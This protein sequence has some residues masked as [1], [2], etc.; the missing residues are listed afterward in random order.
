MDY[1][2]MDCKFGRFNIA[3]NLEEEEIDDLQQAVI[4]YI[5]FGDFKMLTDCIMD[6]NLSSLEKIFE[7]LLERTSMSIVIREAAAKGLVLRK[8]TFSELPET[9]I[10]VFTRGIHSL[11]SDSYIL[12][13]LLTYANMFWN[14]NQVSSHFHYI[15]QTVR[16]RNAY[17]FHTICVLVMEISIEWLLSPEISELKFGAKELILYCAF[18][19]ITQHDPPTKDVLLAFKSLYDE[20]DANDGFISFPEMAIPDLRE[21]ISAID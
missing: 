3:S 9:A 18:L 5:N 6:A 16:S 10:L 4:N 15:L 21:I 2:T 14:D 17:R 11:E 7:A 19:T 8:A 13:L 12:A 1:K 20:F